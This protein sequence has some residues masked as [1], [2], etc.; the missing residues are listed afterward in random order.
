MNYTVCGHIFHKHCIFEWL[1]S[2]RTCP[3]CRENISS[4]DIF[5]IKWF[6]TEVDEASSTEYICDVYTKMYREVL[7]QNDVLKADIGKWTSGL[8]ATISVSRELQ[9]KY[10][11]TMMAATSKFV[12]EIDDVKAGEM[13]EKQRIARYSDMLD[14]Y[15]Q[16]CDELMEDNVVLVRKMEENEVLEDR[17]RVLKSV[18][19]KEEQERGNKREEGLQSSCVPDVP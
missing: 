18:I 14:D 2:S 4:G 1:K 6:L 5:E 3:Q 12:Q 19:Q 16:T 7:R 15:Q 17:V 8:R 9:G 11:Q 13:D 10:E